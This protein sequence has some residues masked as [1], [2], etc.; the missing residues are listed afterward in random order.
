MPQEV[1]IPIKVDGMDE[2]NKLV[3]ALKNV[4]QAAADANSVSTS[5]RAP[6]EQDAHVKAYKKYNR[7]RMK[8]MKA[9]DL[10]GASGIDT[11]STGGNSNIREIDSMLPQKKEGA[12]SS[13][14]MA[15]ALGLGAVAG[16]AAAGIMLLVKVL[17]DALSQSKIASGFLGTLSKLMGLLIDVVLLPFLPILVVV[18]LALS[19]SIML[20]YG[21]MSKLNVPS[22]TGGSGT[23]ATAL[24][25]VALAAGIAAAL[26]AAIIVALIGAT[27]GWAVVA[28]VIIGI[29][30][31]YLVLYEY[32]LGASVGKI[33]QPYWASF[34]LWL[35]GAATTVQ[36]AWNGFLTF[37]KGIPETISSKWNGFL[38]FLKGIPE[39]ISSK[40]NSLITSISGWFTNLY[41][42]PLI[43]W[44]TSMMGSSS[45]TAATPN[46]SSINQYG[47]SGNGNYGPT[48]SNTF[49]IVGAASAD[50]NNI[51]NFVHSALFRKGSQSPGQGSHG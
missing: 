19:S 51:I 32:Q 26:V 24:N 41:N 22:L 44:L 12:G 38:T 33:L 3:S 37:L 1:K 27:G 28:V 2:L 30:T 35:G 10:F 31:Y 46:S 45:T 5:K 29:L 9:S 50:M 40:W 7:E 13:G 20:L 11:I 34:I 43:K 49:N 48:Q 6:H 16:M 25:Y 39:T 4:Q 47:G 21:V 36:N 42:N 18:L 23:G 14:G 8:G 15:N 17:K